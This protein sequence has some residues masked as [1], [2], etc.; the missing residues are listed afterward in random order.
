[1]FQKKLSLLILI[2]LLIIP[3]AFAQ[4]E[5]PVKYREYG[6]GSNMFTFTAGVV[7]PTFFY[8]PYADDPFLAFPNEM[9]MKLGGY[10]SIRYQSFVN[11]VLAL[12]GELGYYFGYD[13]GMDLFTSV[14]IQAKLTYIPL[15]GAF[16][17]PLSL[18]LGIAYNSY[19]AGE[20]PSYL[21]M[22]GS[23]EAGFSW[24]FKPDWGITVSS[25][26]QFIPE[27]YFKNHPHFQDTTLAAFMPITLSVTYRSN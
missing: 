25:G 26:L 19:Q 10:G 23:L 18:G 4:D 14:P 16:E 3:L 15:Q 2:F 20:K 9:H 6:K 13:L 17:I 27:I 5:A 12:G 22:F 24:F 11:S 21:S 1:M 8:R 7:L